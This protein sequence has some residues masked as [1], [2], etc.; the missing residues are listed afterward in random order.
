MSRSLRYALTVAL[1]VGLVASTGCG[2][3]TSHEDIVEGETFELGE[4]RYN[5]LYFRNLNS[6]DTEDA[7]YLEGQPPPPVGQSYFAAFLLIDNLSSEE[8][9]LPDKDAFEVS[10]TSGAVYEPIETHGLYEFPYG[11][12]I[13][14]D[15]EVP[16]PDS[17][18]AYGPIQGSMV[19][20]L[21]AEA[22]SESRPLE[23]SIKTQEGDALVQLDL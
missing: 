15:S 14:G 16:D 13:E 23:M 22:V 9:T 20:F 4:L 3:E 10:D 19:L 12:K 6:A 2:G 1:A 21:M 7:E 11:A 5:V 8:F 18:A 17:T